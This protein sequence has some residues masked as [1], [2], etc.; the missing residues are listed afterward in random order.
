M[1]VVHSM[2]CSH[3]EHFLAL[4]VN[5]HSDRYLHQD[6]DKSTGYNNSSNNY[7]QHI[8]NL[9]ILSYN[10]CEQQKNNKFMLK[11]IANTD[12][13]E[14]TTDTTDTTDRN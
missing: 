2:H 4:P 6:D 8:L 12:L 9:I 7:Y 10:S 1:T 11:Y 13:T 3:C 14:V 5:F